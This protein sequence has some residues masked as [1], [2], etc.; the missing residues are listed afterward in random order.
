MKVADSSTAV[1]AFSS[2]H[3]QREQARIA[4]GRAPGIVAH[5]AFE[6]YSV[7]TRSPEPF[8]APPTIAIEWI[9]GVFG[10]RWLS[11]S[12][13]GAQLALRR[14]QSVGVAGGAT[15]DGLIA[16]TAAASGAALVTL[17]VRALATYARVGVDVELLS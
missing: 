11:L 2:W 15:Y 5:A 3:P 9:E 1:A 12:A 4:L 7:L 8:R 6:A 17:D 13:G 14:L 16:I 10:N